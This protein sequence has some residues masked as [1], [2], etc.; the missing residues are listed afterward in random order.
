MAKTLTGIVTSDKADKTIVISIQSRKTHALYKKQY[1]VTDKFMAHDEKNEAN[2]GDKVRIIETKPISAK[3]RFTLDQV[4][5]KAG[6][7][8]ADTD[9]H[10]AIEEPEEKPPKADKKPAKAETP[11]KEEKAK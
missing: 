5:E 9:V 8:Y 4:I 11:V 2:V 1:T 6:I 10:P 7:E 3:K